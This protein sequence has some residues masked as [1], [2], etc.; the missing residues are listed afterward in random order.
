LIE[1]IENIIREFGGRAAGSRQEYRAQKYFKKYL[2]SF[3]DTTRIQEFRVA[4]N[5]KFGSIPYFSFVL[6]LNFFLYWADI[7]W[8]L[9][10]SILNAVLFIGHFVSYHNWL[11]FLFKKHASW[12]VEGSKSPNLQTKETIIISGHMDCVYEFKWW[13][14][15]KK[16]GFIF[17]FTGSVVIILQA[18]LF[19]CIYVLNSDPRQFQSGWSLISYLLLAFMS[20]T[21][22]CMFDMHSNKMVDGAIDN[23]SGV[24]IASDVLKFFSLDKRLKHIEVRAVSFG[25]EEVGLRGSTAYA[26]MLQKEGKEN[27]TVI[28]ID[29][30]RSPEHL[31]II[32][33]EQNPLT[34]YN[35]ALIT[36]LSESFDDTSVDYKI[37]SIG[38]GATD[39]TSFHRKGFS[40]VSVIGIDTKNPDP[41]YH[42]R[43]DKLENLDP[44]ALTQLKQVI[45]S[46]ISKR[47]EML[48]Q[49]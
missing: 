11:D 7:R 8:A 38:I 18:V 13:Y 10:L 24:A 28:N 34:F 19:I 26:K 46:F 15:L 2:D 23:L 22:I 49:K 16:L 32:S 40:C 37:S 30:I 20:L 35:K 17:T 5:A 12:N 29:T 6:Y 1:L 27:I 14:R 4:I 3:S 47:D 25:S 39:G 21:N 48:M 43:L 31:N 42:T 9:I 36:E 41:T 45:I 44:L 33:S